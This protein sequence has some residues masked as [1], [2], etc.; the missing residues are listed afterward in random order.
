MEG[1]T[2]SILRVQKYGYSCLGAARNHDISSHGIGLPVP[3]LSSFSPKWVNQT[4]INVKVIAGE[5]QAHA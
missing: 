3:E 4:Q 2:L 5:R 1:N